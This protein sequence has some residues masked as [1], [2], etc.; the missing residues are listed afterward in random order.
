[1]FD[2][3]AKYKGISLN[4]VIYQGP[5][6]QN[7]LLVLIRFRREPIALMC[8]IAE[9][10][11][12]I[13]LSSGDRPYHR[14]LWHGLET[15][16]Q[17]DVYEFSRFVF[18][19]NPSPFQ[20]QFVAHHHAREYQ[21]LYPRAAETVLKSRYVDDSMDSVANISGCIDLY[22]QLRSCGPPQE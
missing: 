6:L 11:L 14:F 15:N 4:D 22:K 12:L 18:G 19:V 13:E 9:I 1:V 7:D 5:K 20:A 16:R 2:A 10:Y 17:P 8:D 3:S 21:S